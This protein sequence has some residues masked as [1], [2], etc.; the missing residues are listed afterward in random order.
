M[1]T[2]VNCRLLVIVINNKPQFRRSGI[3]NRHFAI[4]LV[5]SLPLPV[6]QTLKLAIIWRRFI[7][8]HKGAPVYCPA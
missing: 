2:N 4:N 7:G 1:T 8:L 5:L 3:F 6:K